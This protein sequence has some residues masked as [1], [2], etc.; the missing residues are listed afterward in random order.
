MRSVTH[1]IRKMYFTQE[2]PRVPHTV[3]YI[4]LYDLI[5]LFEGIKISIQI[6]NLMV[7]RRPKYHTDVCIFCSCDVNVVVISLKTKKA[8]YVSKYSITCTTVP[9]SPQI[10]YPFLQD[11]FENLSDSYLDNADDDYFAL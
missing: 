11:R 1:S 8:L 7:C 2:R 6:W 5:P 10:S 4:C 3:C 9:H